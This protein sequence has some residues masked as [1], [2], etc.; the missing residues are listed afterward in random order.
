M[1]GIF[2]LHSILVLVTTVA[3]GYINAGSKVVTVTTRPSSTRRR[4]AVAIDRQG[5]AFRSPALL[6][7]HHL[8]HH[9]I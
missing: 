7:T 3:T 1:E 2:A 5:V 6:H 9:L 4:A 8:R